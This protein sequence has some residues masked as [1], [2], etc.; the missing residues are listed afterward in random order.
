MASNYS[1]SSAT[2]DI[3]AKSISL[4]GS[5]VY[6]ASATAASGA[7]TIS[8]TVG[9]QTLTLTGNGTLSGGADVGTK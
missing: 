6:D 2:L 4:S 3:N 1:L 9:G 7:L 5:K 8:G